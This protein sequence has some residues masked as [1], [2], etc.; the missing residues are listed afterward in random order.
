QPTTEWVARYNGPANKIDM[1]RAMAVD[2]NANIYVTG[3]S[4]GTKNGNVDIAIVKYNAAGQ[5]KWAARYNGTGNGEDWPYEIA[6]GTDG[7]YVTGRSMGIN[8]AF[9]IV[10]IKYDTLGSLKWVARYN[11]TGNLTDMPS[12]LK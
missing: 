2:A 5:Q 7:V 8:S 10:T 9:D 11:G 1:V 4:D 3:P 6:V 12:D